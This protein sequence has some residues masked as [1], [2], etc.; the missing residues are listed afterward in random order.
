MATRYQV[1]ADGGVFDFETQRRV[2]P[3]DTTAW[4]QYEEWVTA[5]GVALPPD[6][7][8]QQTLAQ[9]QAQ[10]VSEINAYASCLRNA[11]VRGRSVAEMATWTMLALDALAVKAGGLSLFSALLPAVQAALNLPTL[12]SSISAALGAVRGITEVQSAN[13][14]LAQAAPFLA[15]QIAIEGVRGAHVDAIQSKVDIRDVVSYAWR[16]GWPV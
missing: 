11:A 3:S 2:L 7:I 10:R 15:Q 16:T 14:V 4:G 5:G 1:V 12:P 9:A 6:F 8:G 13:K